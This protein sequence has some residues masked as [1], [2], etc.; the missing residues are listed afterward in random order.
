LQTY[1]HPY[2]SVSMTLK[3]TQVLI[4]KETLKCKL[5]RT[6]KKSKLKIIFTEDCEG[7]SFIVIY[8]KSMY[9]FQKKTVVFWQDSVIQDM[10]W[11]LNLVKLTQNNVLN[12]IYLSVAI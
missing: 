7:I 9:I 11:R 1:I 4:L 2:G 10:W 8:D 5:K 12:A 3:K 6:L